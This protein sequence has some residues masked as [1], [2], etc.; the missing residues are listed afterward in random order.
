[1]RPD[2]DAR[3]RK[4]VESLC[5]NV[6]RLLDWENLSNWQKPVS[7]LEE[8]FGCPTAFLSKLVFNKVRRAG[9][10]ICFYLFESFVLL[11][12]HKY[13][14]VLLWK[15]WFWKFW[16]LFWNQRKGDAVFCCDSV[17]SLLGM[18]LFKNFYVVF[19]SGWDTE[20]NSI[21]HR[22]K[23]VQK[24]ACKPNINLVIADLIYWWSDSF[25]SSQ[26]LKVNA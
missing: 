16:S 24:M 11:L 10:S 19:L 17:L 23:T 20:P 22:K 2:E 14:Y 12:T 26:V 15:P 4:Q 8:Q 5:C 6:F 1:M 7:V 18:W 3:S 9:L 25:L 21:F 13:F